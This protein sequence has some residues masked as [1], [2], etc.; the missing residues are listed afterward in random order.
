MTIDTKFNIGEIVLI[1][2]IKRN[3]I[4]LEMFVN[5]YGVQYRVRYCDNSTFSNVTLF[6][7]ELSNEIQVIGSFTNNIN[8]FNISMSTSNSVK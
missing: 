1:K 7:K 6:E 8:P 4:I 2:D 5:E 3:G